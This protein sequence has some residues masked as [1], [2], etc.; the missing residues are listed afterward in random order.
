MKIILVAINSKFIH[1]NLAVRYLKRFTE[2]LQYTCKIEEFSINDRVERIVEEII[3]DKPDVVAFSCYIWNISYIKRVASL[4]RL[5]N[6]QIK[7]IFGGPEVS[8]DAKNYLIEGYCDF[9]IEG[10]GEETYKELITYLLERDKN[11]KYINN[12]KSLYYVG[13]REIIYTG[14]R[15]LMDINNIVFPYEDLEE[16]EN[17]IIYYEASRGCPFNCKYC[18]SSTVHGVRFLNI[19][20]VKRE[21]KFFIS[22]GVTLLKFID[23]TFNCNH[24]FAYDIWK[25]IIEKN[26]PNMTFHF[27]ISADLLTEKEISL[28]S[29]APK[30]LIQFEVGVQSTNKEVLKNINRNAD[31]LEIKEKVEELLKIK[32]INQ[33]LDLIAGLPG[34]DYNSFKESFN[35][36]YSIEPDQI[37]LGFLK[38]LKGSSM[39]EEVDKWGMVYSPYTPY[40]ILKTNN[41]SYEEILKLK[42]IEEVLDKYYNSRKFNNILKYFLKKFQT[43]FEFYEKLSEYF[44]DNGYFSRSISSVEYYKVFLDFNKEI[45]KE[46]SY[47]LEEIIKYDYLKFNKKRWLPKFLNRHMDKNEERHI[48]M[49][50]KEQGIVDKSD[51][52]ND[53]H[54]E[55]FKVDV[56]KYEEVSVLKEGEFFLLFHD[57]NRN[58]V[59]NITTIVKRYNIE[60]N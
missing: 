16:L 9:L 12:I 52:I 41:I 56:L 54:I 46:K 45:L 15:N 59:K 30:G 29:K 38:L 17:K 4:I 32:N 33:H 34:E 31:F 25:F 47:I 53:Y 44:Y 37:Q 36:L 14:E 6:P 3:L 26:P 43:P 49:I 24:E 28:L 42:K 60:Y 21:L 23:R 55:K 19:D 10:E 40:E 8:F 27:E 2:D 13:N 22:K 1:S 48:K 35:D 7:I 39:R 58:S 50:L 57:N 11:K 20:R 5:I 51:N 18:L